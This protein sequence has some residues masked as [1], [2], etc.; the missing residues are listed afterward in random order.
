MDQ[1]MLPVRCFTCGMPARGQI[2]NDYIEGVYIDRREPGE[3]LDHIARK[4]FKSG[5]Q[6]MCCRAML[7]T[8][9]YTPDDIDIVYQEIQDKIMGNKSSSS[10]EPE[11][12]VV[13]SVPL[14][15]TRLRR[16]AATAEDIVQTV[17]KTEPTDESRK[18]KGRVLLAK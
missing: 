15:Q 5:K 6:N 12:D 8:H 11:G 18:Y 1:I 9:P 3:V 14:S 2:T 16:R 13:Y 10:E 17:T 4:Y 7:M